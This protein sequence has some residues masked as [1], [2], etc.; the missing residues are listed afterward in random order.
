MPARYSARAKFSFTPPEAIMFLGQLTDAEVREGGARIDAG[1][2]A[3][4]VWRSISLRDAAR[5]RREGDKVGRT[6]AEIESESEP[7]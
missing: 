6:F 3:L 2:D 4:A 7:G 1:E 5:W